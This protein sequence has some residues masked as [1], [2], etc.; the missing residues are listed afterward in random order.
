MKTVLL[1][2]LFVAS[3]AIASAAR[4]RVSLNGCTKEKD[5]HDYEGFPHSDPSV[6]KKK[7]TNKFTKGKCICHWINKRKGGKCVTQHEWNEIIYEAEEKIRKR[8]EREAYEK[9]EEERSA[10]QHQRWKKEDK[11]VERQMAEATKLLEVAGRPKLNLN[12][13]TKEKDGHEHNGYPNSD[14]SVCKSQ[15]ENFERCICVWKRK[16]G[17]CVNQHT[18]NEIQYALEEKVAKHKLLQQRKEAAEKE[19]A[20]SYQ[21]NREADKEVEREMGLHRL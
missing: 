7:C 2:T 15:C 17:K 18:Y 14:P 19:A 21:R 1:I 10:E 12:G 13:C 8:K 9:A 11:E 5:G 3:C 16:R 20:A 6:C 4:P